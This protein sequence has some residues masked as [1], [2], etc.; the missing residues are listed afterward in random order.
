MAG[1][2]SAWSPLV[3]ETLVS[4][5]QRYRTHTSVPY[6][7]TENRYW[8]AVLEKI[9]TNAVRYLS[10]RLTEALRCHCTCLR[11]TALGHRTAVAFCALKAPTFGE[12]IRRR[13]QH[14]AFL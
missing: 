9:S 8:R 1:I 7:P 5:T 4:F 3:A 11:L 10:N 14:R 6:L 2:G 12:W 13:R